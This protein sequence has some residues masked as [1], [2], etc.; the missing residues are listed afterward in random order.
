MVSDT[1]NDGELKVNNTLP[2]PI[3][4]TP[5]FNAQLVAVHVLLKLLGK[6]ITSP[7][8]KK[9]KLLR[10]FL[11]AFSLDFARQQVSSIEKQLCR[12]QVSAILRGDSLIKSLGGLETAPFGKRRVGRGGPKDVVKVEVIVTWFLV[13]I[14]WYSY[15]SGIHAL[16]WV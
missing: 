11:L 5:F 9:K 2:I 12:W 7:Q 16:F 14:A 10:G 4:E 6:L 1:V 13:G 15:C 3:S 8:K